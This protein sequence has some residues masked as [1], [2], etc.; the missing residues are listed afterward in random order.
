MGVVGI[1]KLYVK[2]WW[3]LFLALKARLFFI[4]IHIL[5]LNIELFKSYFFSQSFGLD[6]SELIQPNPIIKSD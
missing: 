4:K 6:Y 5:F 2:I 1:P 3:P